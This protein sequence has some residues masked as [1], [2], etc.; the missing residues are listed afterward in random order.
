M[1]SLLTSLRI[2]EITK[3]YG[4]GTVTAM[5]IMSPNIMTIIVLQVLKD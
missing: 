5:E 4:I 3:F 1:F 2:Q